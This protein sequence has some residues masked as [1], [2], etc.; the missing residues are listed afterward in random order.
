MAIGQQ[1]PRILIDLWPQF[2]PDVMENFR[3]E[4]VKTGLERNRMTTFIS[5]QSEQYAQSATPIREATL[6][7]QQSQLQQFTHLILFAFPIQRGP[8]TTHSNKSS[9]LLWALPRSCDWSKLHLPSLSIK[10]D[11]DQMMARA[12][13]ELVAV[14]F[15]CCY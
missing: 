7:T 6:S 3:T 13:Q 1:C 14:L 2:K 10:V 15:L 12:S 4:R 5:G 11:T 9:R 8:N